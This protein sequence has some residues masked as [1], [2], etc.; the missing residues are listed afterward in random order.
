MITPKND[1][2]ELVLSLTKNCETL[3]KET[4]KEAKGTLEYKMTK[5]SEK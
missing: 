1:T 4:L 3:I 2:E 5:P